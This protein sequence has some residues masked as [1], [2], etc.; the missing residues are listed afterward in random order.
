[1]DALGIH[2]GS[3]VADVGCGRGYFTFKF[4][5]RVGAQGKVYAEDIRE[6]RLDEVRGRA[7][8]EHLKQVETIHGAEDDPHLPPNTLDAALVMNAYHEFMDH[9]AMLAG[10]LRAL[11]PGGLL[12]L[13]DGAA[14]VGH[15]REY[16][17]GM[18]KLPE[19]FEREDALR[20]GFHFLREEPGFTQ[21]DDNKKFYF[22]IFEKPKPESRDRRAAL[23]S[24]VLK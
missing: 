3:F 19:I 7:T 2:A 18:H 9:Q 23:S 5:A 8:A 24:S 15:P 20:A 10:I 14:T 6:D 21:P 22:L 16:Y 11:K 17:E 13:I 12:A 1:M 4:A